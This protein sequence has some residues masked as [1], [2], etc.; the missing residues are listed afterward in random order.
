[1]VVDWSG[2]GL[3]KDKAGGVFWNFGDGQARINKMVMDPLHQ[4]PEGNRSQILLQELGHVL[5]LGDSSDSRDIMHPRMHSRSYGRGEFAKLTS[6][7][8]QA[9]QWLY[10]QQ[11]FVP[12]VSTSHR[13]TSP[14]VSEQLVGSASG[15]LRFEP[16]KVEV[17]GAVNVRL[18]L[19]N[20][21]EESV[22]GPLALELWGRVLGDSQWIS[23]KTWQGVNQIPAGH[24]VSRDYFS[25]LQPLFV[26]NFELLCKVYRTDTKEVLGESQY[27]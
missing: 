11:T 7:D 15:A 27:P 21:S 24:R 20:P 18:L 14:A 3:P 8:L 5:G 22:A 9:F 16:M 23:L 13:E 17:T 19:R 25:D 10:S 1:M 26:G 4:I 12:I 2:K 6:R